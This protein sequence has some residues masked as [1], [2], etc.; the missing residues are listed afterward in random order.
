MGGTIS[1]DSEVGKWTTFTVDL[2]FKEEVVDTNRFSSQLKDTRAV[3]ISGNSDDSDY[4]SWIFEKYGVRSSLFGSMKA[5]ED[6]LISDLSPNS[7]ESFVCLVDEDLYVDESYQLLS[8]LR[9]SVLLTYGKRFDVGRSSDHYRSIRQVLPSALMETIAKCMKTVSKSGLQPKR[10]SLSSNSLKA[11]GC[12][13]YS[14]LRVLVA[15]DNIVNQKVISKLLQRIGVENFDVAN[16]GAQAVKAEATTAYDIILMDMQM[17]V[18]DGLEACRRI[19]GRPNIAHPK[20]RVIFAT[21]N[22]A[23]SYEAL[24]KEAGGSGFLPKPFNIAQV[25]KC[26]SDALQDIEESRPWGG[27]DDSHLILESFDESHFDLG[28][29]M[30]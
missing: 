14:H 24:C 18:M 21:A 19:M 23:N 6:A 5:M 4:L 10:R 25:E 9:T 7:D 20:P 22:A 1:V 13:P 16:D 2:P 27:F 29:L 15:E 12:N 11:L 17:P 30:F 28:G 3:I 26:L 8:E